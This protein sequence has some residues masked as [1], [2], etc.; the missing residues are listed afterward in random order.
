MDEFN[1][2]WHEPRSPKGLSL[3]LIVAVLTGLAIFA[4]IV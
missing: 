4:Y 3:A 2:H 1:E